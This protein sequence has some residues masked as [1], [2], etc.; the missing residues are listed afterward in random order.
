[1]KF[2]F[3]S[4]FNLQGRKSVTGIVKGFIM[5]A[6]TY[7]HDNVVGAFIIEAKAY[8]QVVLFAQQISFRQVQIKGDS[9]TVI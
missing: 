6:C 3:D 4:S 5:G 7:L 8:E 2:N 9:L 1:M